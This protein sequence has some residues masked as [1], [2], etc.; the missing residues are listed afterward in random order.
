MIREILRPRG[1]GEVALVHADPAYG[2]RE[3]T[4]RKTNRRGLVPTKTR[5]AGYA[6]ARDFDE[7]IGDDQPYDP[8]LLLDLARPLVLWGAN[9]YASRLPDRAGW[10]VWDKRD[11][12]TSDDNGDVELAW[13]SF[14]TRTRRFGHAWR[15]LARAS[16]TATK[17]LGPTQ[18][19]IALSAWVFAEAKLRRGD[20]VFVPYLGSG[21]DLPVAL[22]LGLRVV[23]CDVSRK[24]CRVAVSRL[25]AAPDP[26]PPEELGPLFR[27]A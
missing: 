23:A 10:M 14:L 20:L 21:P 1:L 12:T 19:P 18:K 9:H 11:G 7:V 6:K 8:R 25:R 26:E 2:V 5:V 27:G 22:A 16:E 17:H 15:G 3:R 13:T 24:C 4:R